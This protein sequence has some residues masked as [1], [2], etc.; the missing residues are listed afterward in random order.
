MR[1]TFPPRDVLRAQTKRRRDNSGTPGL[2]SETGSDDCVE[3]SLQYLNSGQELFIRPLTCLKRPRGLALYALF[4]LA[5]SVRM[6]AASF[7]SRSARNIFANCA[8]LVYR[9]IRPSIELIRGEALPVW[10]AF[11]E[12]R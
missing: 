11:F 7:A 9:T 5:M 10:L 1:I 4:A 6:T 12:L 2:L 8:R 3:K